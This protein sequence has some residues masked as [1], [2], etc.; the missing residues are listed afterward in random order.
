MIR[1]E[2]TNHPHGN[3][4]ANKKK[5][6]STN[7]NNKN[8]WMIGGLIA[9]SFLLFGGAV[10]TRSWTMN[11][12]TNNLEQLVEESVVSS[13]SLGCSRCDPGEHC[14]GVGP[15]SMCYCAKSCG[16]SF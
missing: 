4:V 13:M 1:H 7:R 12:N 14:C 9:I 2:H 8:Y 15:H 5:R 11:D 10:V 3:A 6:S 16:W